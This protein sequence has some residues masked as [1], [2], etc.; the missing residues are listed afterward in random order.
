M[1]ETETI[2]PKKNFDFVDT[3]RCISMFGIVFEHS[4]VLDNFV[5]TDFY[6]SMLQASVMQFFKFSTIAF[7]IIAGFLINYKLTEYTPLQYL[8]NRF[9]NTIGPWAFWLNTLILLDI[10]NLFVK[11]YKYN[12]ERPLLPTSFWEYLGTEYYEIIGKTSFW[13]ILN[14]LI[15][16]TILLIF[17]KYLY[18]LSFGIFL[19]LLSLFYSVNLHYGWVITSHTTALFGFVFFLWLGVYFSTNFTAIHNFIKKTP[20]V[21]LILVTAVFFIL[22]DLE[23]IYLQHS[24]SIDSYNT[25]RITNIFY[26]LSFFALLLKIDS[27][28]F[29]NSMFQPRKTTYGIYLIHMLVLVHLIREI[30]RPFHFQMD[31]MSIWE[32]TG[33]CI[34]RFLI[35]YSISMIVV[36]IIMKTKFRWS[37][38]S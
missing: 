7:F 19:C 23:T 16:I 38:G 12:K 3:I 8:K 5:Y 6:T 14:F 31:A 9:K 37:I 36:R 15:C 13:F 33:Y 26:S 24:G 17:K 2:S 35:I 21:Q 4:T 34:F 10:V 25:L 1:Q 30:C 29:I 22:A 28:P 27:I 18:K 32:L 20:T 11:Y